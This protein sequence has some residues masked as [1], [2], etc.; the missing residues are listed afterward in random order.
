MANRSSRRILGDYRP[1]ES[2]GNKIA[3]MDVKMAAVESNLAKLDRDMDDMKN[4]HLHH[5]SMQLIEVQ[6]TLTGVA[7]CNED[8]EKVKADVLEHKMTLSK[9]NDIKKLVIAGMGVV[10]TTYLPSLFEVVRH[11]IG[12]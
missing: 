2:I 12:R 4:N 3:V 11:F 1:D 6:H 5:I 7:N 9:I 10:A 8:L